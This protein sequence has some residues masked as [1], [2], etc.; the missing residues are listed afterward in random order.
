MEGT[1]SDEAVAQVLSFLDGDAPEAPAAAPAPGP[2]ERAA[3]QVLA[4]R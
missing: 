2:V 1:W 3:Q 4:A